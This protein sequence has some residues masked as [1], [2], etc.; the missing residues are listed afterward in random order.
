MSNT[1]VG[2]YT[3]FSSDISAEDK[4]TFVNAFEKFAGVKYEPIAVATQVVAGTNYAF[5]CN[6]TPVYPGAASNPAMVTIFRSL[7]GHSSI[8]HIE[9]MPY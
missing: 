6:A 3:P 2:S 4:T 5:F 7:E 9:K 1:T 8:T